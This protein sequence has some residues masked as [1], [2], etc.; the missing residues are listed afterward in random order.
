MHKQIH[1]LEWQ[2]DG[3]EMRS[4]VDA[5]IGNCQTN[6]KVDLRKKHYVRT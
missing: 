2:T 3:Q 1:Y 5:A 6:V 4:E